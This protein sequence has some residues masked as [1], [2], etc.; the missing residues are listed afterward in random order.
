MIFLNSKAMFVWADNML[1]LFS[2]KAWYDMKNHFP[3]TECSY[4]SSLS[5]C[6][7]GLT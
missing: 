1:G 5:F 4:Q 2:L 3:L 7:A 6:I